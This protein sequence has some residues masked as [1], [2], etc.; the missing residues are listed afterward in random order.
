MGTIK[1]VFRILI[2]EDDQ[3]RIDC[4]RSWLDHDIRLVVASSAGRALGILERDKGYVYAGI[5]LDHDLEK[6]AATDKDLDTTGSHLVIT[7][8]RNIDKDVPILVHSMN[9]AKAQ[10]M[11]EKLSDAGF[12]VSRIPMGDLT[13][14]RLRAWVEDAHEIWEDHGA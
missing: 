4:F 6:Q 9:P 10:T 5:L 3:N 13:K 14:M 11:V 7:I 2:I 12:T 8:I 1:R